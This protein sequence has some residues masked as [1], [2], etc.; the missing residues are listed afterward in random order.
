VEKAS[1]P[2]P[3]KPLVEAAIL[4]TNLTKVPERIAAAQKAIANRMHCLD[5]TVCDAE[6]SALFDAHNVV[7][8]LCK[9]AGLSDQ[10]F[11]KA[12]GQ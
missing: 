9:M 11:R 7:C 5:G 8:D 6:R 12:S 10:E 4:E 3:W 2:W 1:G